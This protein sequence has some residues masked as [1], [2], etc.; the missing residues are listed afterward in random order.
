MTNYRRIYEDHYGPIP[1]DSNGRSYDI[2]HKDGNRSNNDLSNLEALSIEDHFEKHKKQGDFGACHAIAMRMNKTP[3]EFSRIA[4]ESAIARVKR[5][6]NPFSGP[7]WNERLKREGRHPFVGGM[8][9]GINAR[10][11]VSEGRHPFLGG[12]IQRE[13]NRKRVSNGTHNFLGGHIQRKQLKEGTHNFQLKRKCP[14]CD[15]TT[16]PGPL[17]C[18][19]KRKHND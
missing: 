11:L 7:E 3:E 16:T 12:H 13:S 19:I 2:H 10:K 5:G 8:Q 4:S 18:H 15:L 6:D 14:H 9:S 17:A 1:K